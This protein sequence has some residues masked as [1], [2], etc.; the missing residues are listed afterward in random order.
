MQKDSKIYVAGHMGMVGSA[1]LRRLKAEGCGNIVT[2]TLAELDLCRQDDVE[3]FFASERPEV[4]FLAAAGVGGIMANMTNQAD[5]LYENPA[6]QN[7]VMNTAGRHGTKKFVF[8]GSSC[9]YPRDCQQ[10]IKEA[11]FNAPPALEDR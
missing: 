9:I 1:I 8:L 6:I 3:S 10:P 4:V 5:F 11:G 2:R 7:N